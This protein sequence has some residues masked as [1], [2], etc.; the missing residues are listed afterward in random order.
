[1]I[2]WIQ[3]L[4]CP[5]AEIGK[6]WVPEIALIYLRDLF[7]SIGLKAATNN[8]SFK[9]KF[10]YKLLFYVHLTNKMIVFFGFGLFKQTSLQFLQQ[11]YVKNVHP[12]YGA[13]S[14]THD[15]WNV[16]LFP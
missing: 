6:L 14:Q 1:M 5:A 12:V 15:L 4:P 8:V 2:I 7:L 3:I 11:I 13:G 10:L 16:I 9:C